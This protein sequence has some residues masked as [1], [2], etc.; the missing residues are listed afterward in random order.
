MDLLTTSLLHNQAELSTASLSR[1]PVGT[2]TTSLL[3]A[4]VDLST[5]YLPYIPWQPPLKLF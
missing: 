1:T 2:L 4:P 5:T 3:H